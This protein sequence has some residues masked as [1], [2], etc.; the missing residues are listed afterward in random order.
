MATFRVFKVDK[1]SYIYIY[2]IY[3]HIAN[4]TRNF[5]QNQGGA[6]ANTTELVI[7]VRRHNVTVF[8]VQ[9]AKHVALWH[10]H[11]DQHIIQRKPCMEQ[12]GSAETFL[13]GIW[14]QTELHYVQQ[15]K[16]RTVSVKIRTRL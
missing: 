14:L 13:C 4:N 3:T 15:L 10:D 5:L 12:F 8:I 1:R 7:L 6:H 11:L 2:I 9:L 16:R